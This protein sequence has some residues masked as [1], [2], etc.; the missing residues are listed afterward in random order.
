MTI[1]TL[2]PVLPTDTTPYATLL[3]LVSR[4]SPSG[5]EQEAVAWLVERMRFLGYAQVYRDPAGNA[6]G[7]IGNGEKQIVL[8]GHIDTVPGE[9]TVRVEANTLYGRGS[10]DAKGPLAAFVDAVARCGARPDWQFVVIGC[11]EEERDSDGARYAIEHYCPDFAI[12]GE[13]S[14]WERLTLGYKGCAWSELSLKQTLTHSASQSQSV[15]ETA[16]QLWEAV[17]DWVKEFNTGKG[18]S[19]DKVTL[20]L[21][22]FASGYDG[23]REWARLRV[24]ARLP[25]GLLPAE[26]YRQ[27]NQI[28]EQIAHDRKAAQGLEID[29][30]PTGYSIAAYLGEKNNALVRAFL[31]GIRSTQGKPGFLVKSGTADMNIVAP[32][33]GCPAVAYGPGD[34]SLDHTPNEH[35]PFSEYSQSVE[36][37]Y[38]ML[39]KI[40]KG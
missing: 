13:P 22:G 25:V 39:H 11:V 37:L 7:V 36:V 9:I 35:L 23:F 30:A 40:S 29:A 34:S 38:Q 27:I 10:V 1:D 26:W 3:G 32:V 16:F 33:W 20:N 24:G 5:K 2:L 4:Y 8:L 19:F 12:I 15:C 31:D 28:V 17:H 21:R 6:V 14:G 18:R